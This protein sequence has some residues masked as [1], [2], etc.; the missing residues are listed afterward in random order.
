MKT[1]EDIILAKR[2]FELTS[3]EK[4]L[5]REYAS[6]EEDY[7]A[8]RWFLISTGSVLAQEKIE[9]SSNL[10]NGVMAHLNQKQAAPK[11]LWLNGIAAFFFPQNKP[12]YRYPSFQLAAVAA[13]FVTVV[14]IYNN[15]ADLQPELA[16]NQKQEITPEAPAE[17]VE[18]GSTLNTQDGRNLA[19]QKNLE[20]APSVMQSLDNSVA[21]STIS[22]GMPETSGEAVMVESDLDSDAY[23]RTLAAAEE[24]K[25][26]SDDWYKSVETTDED[27]VSITESNPGGNTYRWTTNQEVSADLKRDDNVDKKADDSFKQSDRAGRSET[28]ASD[29]ATTVSPGYSGTTTTTNNATEG[30]NKNVELNGMGNEINTG[31]FSATSTEESNDSDD[32]LTDDELKE[33]NEKTKDAVEAQQRSYSIAETKKLRKFLLTFK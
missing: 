2:F 33:E 31:S 6:N 3:S 15:N 13:L 20:Q 17:V 14:L 7:E 30:L 19:Q 12:V 23:N 32:A 27:V 29:V 25:V 28:P 10:R 9:P 26:I 16:L 11:G 24:R 1:A 21:S 5:V 4:E 8:M 22:G 18:D